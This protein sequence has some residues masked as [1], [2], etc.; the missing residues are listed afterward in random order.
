MN[1]SLEEL[2][3]RL[4][5]GAEELQLEHLPRPGVVH[6]AV[7]RLRSLL[8]PAG[9]AETN[10][11][12]VLREVR[13]EMV[14]QV[15][16]ALDFARARALPQTSQPRPRYDN[17]EALVDAWL[18]RLPEV[19]RRLELDAQAAYEGDPAATS[20]EEVACCYPGFLAIA[21]HRLAHE[22]YRLGV[23]LVP[24][25]ISERAH[26]LT[27]IDIHPGAQIGERFFIDH[28]TGIVIGETA[29]LGRGVSLYQGVTLGAKKFELDEYGNPVKGVP[30][31][32]I[33]ED[34]VIVYAGATIL[35]RVTIGRGSVIGGNV[36]LT[37][38]VPPG[39]KITHSS[40]KI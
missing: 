14:V 23:P 15:G 30:R 38:S 10:V 11:L 35:G 13:A 25:A 20:P 4:T 39:S 36:W 6:E 17:P 28:G 31:H 33:L 1:V 34:G 22:L 16:R 26:S 3:A 21:Y 29:V 5:A 2:A 7:E 40:E 8:F 24:R 18:E 12:A 9:G 32:P 37:E 19:R 27:G